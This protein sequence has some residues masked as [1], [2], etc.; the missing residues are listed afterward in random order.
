M[1]I[2]QRQFKPTAIG[3]IATLVLLVVLI[4]LGLWQLRRA[5]EKQALI[6]HLHAGAVTTQLLSAENI[7]ALP[8]LQKV[9]AHGHYDTAH[10]ILLDNMWSNA[11]ETG[12]R[13]GCNA[14]TPLQLEDGHIVLVNRGWVPFGRTRADLPQID[15][16]DDARSLHGLISH[17]PEPGMRL[18]NNAPATTWPRLLN[19][20]TLVELRALYGEQ[21]LPRIILLDAAEPD[22]FERNWSARYEFGDFGPD[23]HIG[24]AVQWFGL[25][26]GLLVIYFFVS[27][28]PQR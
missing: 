11:K 15:V 13:P 3:T 19:Y 18:S 2:G 27:F 7:E 9:V 22:G 8:P 23:R 26:F 1:R 10:Q 28:K 16:G 25:A 6:D 12:P 14:F 24:Y 20:P 5:D 21:L 4:N 17:I